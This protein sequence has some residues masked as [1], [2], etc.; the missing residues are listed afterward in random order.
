MD[1]RVEGYVWSD[2]KM[3]GRVDGYVWSDGKMEK[4]KFLCSQRSWF[5]ES[6]LKH[7]CSEA[8]RRLEKRL[9]MLPGVGKGYAFDS[10]AHLCFSF[11]F[12]VHKR[13]NFLLKNESSKKH[14]GQLVEE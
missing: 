9:Q 6:F 14:R 3:D 4:K 1:G 5:Q 7:F 11:N 8:Q 2:G 12:N 10:D 13:R